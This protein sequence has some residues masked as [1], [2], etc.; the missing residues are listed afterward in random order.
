MESCVAVV[1]YGMGNAGSIINM[2]KRIGVRCVPARDA[3]ALARADALVLPGV[4]HFDTGM[5]HLADAGLLDALHDR[6]IGQRCPILGICL[7][8]QLFSRS[9]EEGTLPGLGWIEG[10]T[11]RFD[12]R[13][14]QDQGLR[15][16]HMGWNRVF[17]VE[18][19]RLF[20]P[21]PDLRF[22]HVHSYHMVLDTGDE[23]L[24]Y[25]QYGYRFVSAVEKD[26]VLGVQFHP[27]KSHRFGMEFM[28]RV[29]RKFGLLPEDV[30]EDG[31]LPALGAR[32]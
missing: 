25:T 8:M 15:I 21:D 16:P 18:G 5:Q 9:S 22:Y 19:T 27:E 10:D 2:C 4:G 31:T 1:D 12:V 20:S 32:G 29:F 28:R 3:E 17:P 23:A 11:K 14:M 26:N 24:A 7:G 30:N 13:S 6:V